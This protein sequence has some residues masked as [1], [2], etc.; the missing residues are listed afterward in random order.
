MTGPATPPLPVLLSPVGV[1]GA[2]P[3]RLAAGSCFIGSSKGAHLVITEPTVSRQHCEVEITHG[4]VRITDLD[5]KNGTFYLGQRIDAIVLPPGAS[6]A[7]GNVVVAIH[8]DAERM[9]IEP[10]AEPRYG[11]MEGASLAMRRLFAVVHRLRGSTVPVL[12]EGESGVGKQTLARTLHAA[13]PVAAGPFVALRCAALPRE[14]LSVEIFGHVDGRVGVVERAEGGTLYLDDVDALPLDIQLALLDVLER[15]QS[16]RVGAADAKP[17]TVRLVVASSKGLHDE[18]QAGRFRDALFFRISVVRLAVPPLRDRRDDIEPLARRFATRLGLGPLPSE[19]M[20]DLK[21]RAY[22]GNLRELESLVQTYGVLGALP[23]PTHVRGSLV[24]LAFEEV[25]DPSK[26]YAE[27]KDEIV[28]RFTKRYLQEIMRHAAGN[29]SVAAKLA[30]LD[31]T[32]LGR[33]VAKYGIK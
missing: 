23:A 26:P 5:S 15:G 28:D 2:T 13:S 8:T 18:V 29:Q 3:F 14:L 19:V 27:L 12:I 4:G 16:R 17:A 9:V 1:P 24:D 25:I 20:E 6:F 22:P 32:Y 7:V 10:V 31:R 11:D 33:L 21:T 30:G